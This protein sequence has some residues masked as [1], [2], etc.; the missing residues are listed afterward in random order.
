M[1]THDVRMCKHAW[2]HNATQETHAINLPSDA[3]R[4]NTDRA[5]IAASSQG[6]PLL[7]T[8]LHDRALSGRELSHKSSEHSES[9]YTCI[10]IQ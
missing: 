4:S 7:I 1:Q 10:Y 6:T 2:H 3:P 5:I 8:D 9:L